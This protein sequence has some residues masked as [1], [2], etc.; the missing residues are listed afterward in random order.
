MSRRAAEAALEQGRVCVNGET[1]YLGQSADPDKDLV[2]LDG[3][4]INPNAEKVYIMLHKPAGYVT[5]LS[6]ENGRKTVADLI[7]NAGTR[8]YPVGRLDMYSEG[9]LI[10]TNDGALAHKLMH[11]SFE[12]KKTYKTRVRGENIQKGCEAL[13]HSMEIDGYTV[14]PAQVSLQ[15]SFNGGAELL[16]TISEGRNRQVRKMCEKAGL[17]VIRLIRISEGDLQL[18]DLPAGKW[19]KLNFKEMNYLQNIM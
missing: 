17:K 7:K 13:R 9:L 1:A 15:E 12:I 19:R 8:L 4:P 14:R 18:G 2:T 16:I 6:D 10:C 3:N 5:T 11:P